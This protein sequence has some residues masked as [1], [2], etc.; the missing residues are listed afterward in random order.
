MAESDIYRNFKLTDTAKD[1]RRNMT[2]QEK[3][4]W[5]DYLKN[6]PIRWY[7]QRIIDNFI[8][9]FFCYK[10]RLAIE[11][12][13][14]QH[15]TEQGLAYDKERTAVFN[16]YRIKVLRFSNSDIDNNFEYVCREI[17]KVVDERLKELTL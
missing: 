9:D 4:L 8:A 1:L 17:D 13:G 6:Y 5:Y 3:H 16:A 12:D 2:K 11:I 7:R 15:Y 10:V 14:A